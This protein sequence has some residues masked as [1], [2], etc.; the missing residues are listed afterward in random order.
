[1]ADCDGCLTVPNGIE[2]TMIGRAMQK[3]SDENQIREIL[4]QGAS[5]Q[6]AFKEYEIL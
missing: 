6:K 1:V 2:D 4:Q 3:V 5:I